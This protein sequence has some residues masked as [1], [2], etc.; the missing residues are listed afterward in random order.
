MHSSHK[1]FEVIVI[2]GSFLIAVGVFLYVFINARPH[3]TEEIPPVALPESSYD[4]YT[5]SDYGFS[6]KYGAKWKE[7][8]LGAHDG[9]TDPR[10]ELQHVSGCSLVLG[11]VDEGRLM[12]GYP[13]TEYS[14]FDEDNK[15][16]YEKPVKDVYI[17]TSHFTLI[18]LHQRTQ[19]D[20][21]VHYDALYVPDF[22]HQESETALVL[23]AGIKGLSEECM[24]DYFALIKKGIDLKGELY[25]LSPTSNGT[26]VLNTNN[27]YFGGSTQ[28]DQTNMAFV[29][30]DTDQKNAETVMTYIDQ[31]IYG[32]E[33][34]LVGNSI[35]FVS[36]HNGLQVLDLVTKD[37][38]RIPLLDG[39]SGQLLIPEK[40]NEFFVYEQQLYYLSG[41]NCNEYLARCNLE[42]HEFNLLTKEDFTLATQVISREIIGYDKELQKLYLKYQ[43]GDA[44]CSWHTLQEYDFVSHLFKKTAS[45]SHC[46]DEELSEDMAYIEEIEA[47][48]K[49]QNIHIKSI[50][51]K[52]GKV[53]T[54]QPDTDRYDGIRL[55]KE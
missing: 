8:T 28:W 41:E 37:I 17:D 14:R 5:N 22:P 47:N 33:I 25:T 15:I 24:H 31:V 48:L 13:I 12:S 51:I 3:G 46:D 38:K 6:I 19:N 29:F 55:I 50:A 20:N 4:I 35:Y 23:T 11:T 27:T 52:N 40:I 39:V 18:E 45:A 42:L 54:Y 26:I 34:Q 2:V 30:K 44:G 16:F 10:M 1:R 9:V 53:A 36:P 7:K 32:P 43:D 49:N 21:K